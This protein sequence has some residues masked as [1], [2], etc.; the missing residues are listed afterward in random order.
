MNLKAMKVTT[1]YFSAHLSRGG[2]WFRFFGRG[3]TFTRGTLLFSE[4]YGYQK[5]LKLGF[6]WR[7]KYLRR[8]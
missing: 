6:G 7:V 8:R 2:L 4:R 5:Y 1:R 3:L